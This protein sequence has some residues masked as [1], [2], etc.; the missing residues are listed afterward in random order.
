MSTGDAQ[1]IALFSGRLRARRNRV[2]LTQ[3][4]LA[5]QTGISIRSISAWEAGLNLPSSSNLNLLADRLS[6]TA[7]YLLGEDATP[8]V[9]QE[10]PAAVERDRS[11]VW[12]MLD[13]KT[14]YAIVIELAEKLRDA[15]DQKSKAEIAAEMQSA[16]DE[17]GIRTGGFNSLKKVVAGTAEAEGVLGTRQEKRS[18]KKS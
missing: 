5:E 14:L 16:V 11:G 10:R 8:L 7:S 6:C 13:D 17:V 1:K 12:K 4:G 3:E 18:D 15:Q 2:G 9:L